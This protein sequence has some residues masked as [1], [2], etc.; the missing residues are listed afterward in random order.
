MIMNCKKYG[1]VISCDE[2]LDFY[3][4]NKKDDILS[5]EIVNA[6]I[7]D[8]E[9]EYERT[10]SDLE[11]VEQCFVIDIPSKQYDKISYKIITKEKTNNG[12]IKNI[13]IQ[14]LTNNDILVSLQ[15]KLIIKTV[16]EK[17]YNN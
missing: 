5:L 6:L 11:N 9:T 4:Y 13:H 7:L 14:P 16:V 1:H 2:A 17:W 15:E 10:H 3:S 12:K 8:L